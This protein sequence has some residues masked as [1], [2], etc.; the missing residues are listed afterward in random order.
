VILYYCYPNTPTP[1]V[2][3]LNLEIKSK[4]TVGLVGVTGSGKTTTV[5]IMLGLL[6][7]TKGHLIVDGIEITTANVR[8]WQKNL[9]YVPQSIY[10]TDDTVMRNI[11]FGVRDNEIDNKAVERAARIANL[12]DFIIRD[13]PHGYNTLVG[14]RGVRL[15]GGQRQ[16]IG[17]ARALYHDPKVLMTGLLKMPL[18]RQ[19]GTYPGKKPL[20]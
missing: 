3:N 17:I 15:S 6:S 19:S 10:L 20:S 4:T 16:R 1:A 5:D 13:L 12:H 8:S 14:E 18:W 9:G 11:A 2:T 7:P